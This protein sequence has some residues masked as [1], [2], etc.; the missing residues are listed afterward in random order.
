[1]RKI[2]DTL[3]N[4]I[5]NIIL[6]RIE[7]LCDIFKKL[8]FT[9]NHI[10]TISLIFGLLAIYTL[11][12]GH[13]FISA[14]LLFISYIFDCVDGYYARKYNMV[15]KFGD[16]YDHI[17]DIVVFI[18]YAAV[19]YNRNKKKLSKNELLCVTGIFIFIL[20]MLWVH[21]GCQEYIHDKNQSESLNVFKKLIDNRENAEKMINYTKFFGSGTF[22][23]LFVVFILFIENK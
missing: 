6:D 7:P 16:Y 15:T 22:Y 3:E 17:K 10:T 1:M 23:V 4:H 21:V 12:V 11:Y 18:I 19:L 14:I 5:D 2:P 8:K 20:F 9:P 13:I